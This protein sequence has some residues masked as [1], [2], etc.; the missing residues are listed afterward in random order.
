MEKF[1]CEI[2]RN[3]A[4]KGILHKHRY[5][6]KNGDIYRNVWVYTPFVYMKENS[7]YGFLLLTDG[8]A[9]VVLR[10]SEVFGNVFSQSGSFWYKPE[11]SKEY[12]WVSSKFK[13]IDKLHL[14]F[15]IKVGFLEL[16]DLMIDTKSFFIK[17]L[18]IYEH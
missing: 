4:T 10:K 11:E 16:Q 17:F 18:K 13:D 6:M 3:D 14:K 7:E 8:E 2:E 5:Y 12:N 9:Y 15:Y 1:W